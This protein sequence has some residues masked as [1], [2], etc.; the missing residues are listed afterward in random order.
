LKCWKNNFILND[1]NE[2]YKKYSF[3][4]ILTTG[5]RRSSSFPEKSIAKIV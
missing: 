3:C 1:L 5:A 2:L 4:A